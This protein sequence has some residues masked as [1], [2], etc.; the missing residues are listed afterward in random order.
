[1]LSW[2]RRVA[3]STTS[4]RRER[5]QRS[6]ATWSDSTR[7]ESGA[8][9]DQSVLF[10]DFIRLDDHSHLFNNPHLQRMSFSGLVDL[11]TKPYFNLYIPIT[12]SAWKEP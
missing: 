10:A 8:S 6:A 4:C 2:W 7:P 12:Y 1:M 9:F 5:Q 11:W 3:F